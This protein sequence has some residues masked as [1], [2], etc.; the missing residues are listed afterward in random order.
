MR[1]TNAKNCTCHTCN[2][3]FHYLGIARHRAAHR[4]RKENCEITY[5]RGDRYIHR[6]EE[7]DVR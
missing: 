2:K 1:V 3:N 7:K 6:Y 4:D 5:T